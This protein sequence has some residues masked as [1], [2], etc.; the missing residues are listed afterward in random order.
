M[1]TSMEKPEDN[2]YT[3]NG[4]TCCS[5]FAVTPSQTPP[6]PRSEPGGRALLRRGL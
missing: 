6:Q 5:V 3:R 4:D 2:F 1:L